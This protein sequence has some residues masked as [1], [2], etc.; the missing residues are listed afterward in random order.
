LAVFSRSPQAKNGRSWPAEN[1][2]K[3]SVDL[4]EKYRVVF[5]LSRCEGFTMREI[6]TQL[7]INESTVEKQIAK[8]MQHCRACLERG[9]AG[10]QHRLTLIYKRN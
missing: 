6:A 3:S 2:Q 5:L 1:G 4:P 7:Y 10:T 8:G 9:Y